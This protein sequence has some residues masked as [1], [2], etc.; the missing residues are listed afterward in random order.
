MPANGLSSRVSEMITC[1]GLK[2]SYKASQGTVYAMKNINLSVDTG[3]F[4]VLLGP[5]GSGK[6]TTLRSIAG[7]EQP[8][9]GEIRINHEI[10]YSSKGAINVTPEHRPI[11]MVFQSY[12]LWPNMNVAQNIVFP[13]QHGI[14][15]VSK[16]E[17]GHRLD[18][19]L[20][21]LNL[22]DQKERS[23]SSLSGGQQQ[24]VALARALALKPAVLLMDEPLS[25]LDAK[26]R[27]RLRLELRELTKS[28]GITTIYVTHDQ[29]EAMIMGDSIAI[30]NEG[31][32]KQ[33]GTA[34]ELYE[35]PSSVFVAR[36]LGD[37]NFI[38]GTVQC[39]DGELVQ[40]R[41]ASGTMSGRCRQ[42]IVRGDAA[43]VGFRPEDA[44]L[45]TLCS[46]NVIH[47]RIRNRYYLGESYVYDV[48]CSNCAVQVKSTKVDSVAVGSDILLR[49]R[50]ENCMIFRRDNREDRP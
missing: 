14:R 8:D 33:Q 3:S 23:I 20:K 5:S 15:R 1:E 16:L 49:T 29:T 22:V 31:D 32:V 12:A 11:A 39:A 6:T 30:M 44:E 10:V 7:L 9:S 50:P 42:P 21:L 26:L 25:N 17:V 28:E 37:M 18:H 48:A 24:R 45:T 36:F 2:K 41:T 4:F 34:R 40:I 27:G 13:L 35:N 38:E 46:H 47:G 43:I 19:V